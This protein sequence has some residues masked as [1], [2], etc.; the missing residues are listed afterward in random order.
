MFLVVK[1]SRWALLQAF[2]YNSVCLL[3]HSALSL[4]AISTA[5]IPGAYFLSSIIKL[6]NNE[7]TDE[8]VLYLFIKNEEQ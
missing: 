8:G 7:R 6:M 4:L 3:Q 2:P 5:K 1:A